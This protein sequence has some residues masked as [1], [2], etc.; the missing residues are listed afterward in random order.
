[1]RTA[2]DFDACRA[3]QYRSSL[4]WL[5][6]SARICAGEP[7]AVRFGLVVS[8]RMA[9]KSVQR[10]LV[11]RILREAA[12]HALPRLTDA[13][14]GRHIDVLLRFKAVFPGVAAMPL[15]TFRH[16]LR[17]EAEQLLQRLDDHLAASAP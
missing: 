1:L 10:N 12:R 11:K 5:A 4:R 2:R 14:A 17:A 7:A 8:K 3:P 9:R 16:S 15:P 6:L 13:S